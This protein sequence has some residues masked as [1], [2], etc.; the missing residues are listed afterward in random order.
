MKEVTKMKPMYACCDYDG[1]MTLPGY[2]ALDYFH[3]KDPVVFML[4]P[5]GSRALATDRQTLIAHR[6]KGGAFGI[7]EEDW[8]RM[9]EPYFRKA[10]LFEI[11]QVKEG[12]AYRGIRFASYEELT[13]KPDLKNYVRVYSGELEKGEFLNELWQKFNID[14]PKDFSGRSMSVSDIIVIFDSTKLNAYYANRFGFKDVTEELQG[15]EH[16]IGY[17]VLKNQSD[18]LEHKDKTTSAKREYLER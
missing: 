4:Y 13:G 17:E 9:P 2:K 8:Q 5:D 14:H 12:D 6:D 18:L 16:L 15:K 7:K 10:E 3:P 1:L 11:Y